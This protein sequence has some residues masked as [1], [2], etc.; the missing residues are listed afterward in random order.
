MAANEL[1]LH[2]TL[3]AP[4]VVDA[5]VIDPVGGRSHH[6]AEPLRVEARAA[7]DGRHHLVVEQIV[8]ARLIAAAIDASSHLPLLPCQLICYIAGK[9]GLIVTRDRKF[10]GNL[11][12]SATEFPF[13]W[14]R[15]VA[16]PA[17]CPRMWA[18]MAKGRDR[19][20]WAPAFAGMTEKESLA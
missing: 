14:N 17:S 8:E 15:P 19:Y 6:V 1:I 5:T 4:V 20:P 12:I 10:R 11:T 2:R 7:Q 3:A 9:R 18:S 16:P 13:R